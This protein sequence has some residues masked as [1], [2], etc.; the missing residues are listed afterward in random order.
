MISFSKML[1]ESMP[2]ALI[3]K[4]SCRMTYKQ[5]APVISLVL[6]G[7]EQIKAGLYRQI[8]ACPANRLIESCS[9]LIWKLTSAEVGHRVGDG[10]W[11]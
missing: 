1:T 4:M 7:V 2:R 6:G 5:F 9:W 11:R 8:A 10:R 3:V